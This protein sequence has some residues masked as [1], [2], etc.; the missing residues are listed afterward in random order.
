MALLQKEDI[1][2][3]LSKIDLQARAA[4]VVV[5]LSVYGGACVFR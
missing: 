1:L 2:R 5:D 4:S 3:G